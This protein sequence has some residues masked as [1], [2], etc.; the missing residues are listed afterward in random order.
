MADD[1]APVM[2]VVQITIDG[3]KYIDQQSMARRNW[4]AMER[5]PELR[6]TVENMMRSRLGALVM[7]QLRPP[8]H[9]LMPSPL[10][11]AVVQT[12]AEALGVDRA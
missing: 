6:Q 12:A 7:E 5:D 8:I 4:E 11:E 2:L 1:F 10:D 9:V 3:K